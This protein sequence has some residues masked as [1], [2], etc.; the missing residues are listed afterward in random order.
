MKSRRTLVDR[1]K[2]GQHP[3]I[4]IIGGGC[5]GAGVFRDLALQGIAT[6]LVE[7]G[8]FSSGTSAA[9]TRLAHGGI[10]YLETGEIS[11]VREST[12]ERNLLLM[13]APHQVRPLPV[14]VPLRSWL[15]GALQAPLRF[16]GLTKKLGPKGY[17]AVKAGLI[18]YD[19]FGNSHRTLPHHRMFSRSE[20]LRRVPQL[21]PNIRAVA[22][23]HD[24]LITQPERLVMEM[25]GDGERDCEEAMAIPY[26]EATGHRDGALELRDA[27]T[28]ELAK[29]TPRLVINMAGAWADVVQ[30][31][32]GV[33]DRMVGGR[34]AMSSC[35]TRRWPARSKGGC[36]ISRPTTSV[37]VSCC[38]LVATACFSAR[39]IYVATTP[40]TSAVR[41]RKSTTSLV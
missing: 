2:S 12:I 8:D 30:A 5:N 17:L 33:T 34:A 37:H 4:V 14:W 1:L 25:I 23:Y 32:L 3:D 9:P 24:S 38:T 29:V 39:P 7:K 16:F 40:M 6:L 28:G 18:V 11:L 31:G 20:A 21:N 22:Q 41:T 27:I 26:L 13:N 36:C 15:G 35:A 10:K 19:R